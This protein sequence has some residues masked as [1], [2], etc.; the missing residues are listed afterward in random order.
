MKKVCMIVP[1]F[2][3]KGGIASVVSGYRG[4]ALEQ[5]YRIRYL[6]TYCDGN[7]IKKLWKAICAYGAFLWNLMVFRPDL[8]HIHGSFGA[9]FYRK[10]PFLV[11]ASLARIPVVLH[12]HGSELD[13]FYWQA[14]GM[15][16]SLVRTLWGKSSKI[17]VLSDHWEREF[18]KIFRETTIEVIPN[19]APELP[20]GA[21]DRRT[22][23]KT[24]LFLGFLSRR[25]GC[26]DIP[27]VARL[28]S[29]REPQ[30]RFLLAGTGS[31]EDMQQIRELARRHGVE[32]FLRFPGWV[33]EKEKQRLLENAA[34]FFLPSYTEGLPM[35]V[36]EA[37]AHGLPVVST[38]VGGIPQLVEQGKTGFLLEPG[39]T[40]G[41]ARAILTLLQDPRKRREMG[42][43]GLARVQEEYT[44]DRHIRRL[45]LV[46]AHVMGEN[47]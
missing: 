17:L 46:Y 39:D 28:V 36:L 16:K 23:D 37:M 34:L 14:S 20:S 4:S 41:F 25:K 35:S 6:E 42:R 43:A 18:S 31:R 13:R 11:G 10:A 8:I 38:T 24:V 3:A 22:D 9:S 21:G 1:S 7:Q 44:L 2:T 29:Q 40:E 33:W 5:A 32:G 45:R 15:K 27:E 30:A 19:F 47:T 26:M 12:I